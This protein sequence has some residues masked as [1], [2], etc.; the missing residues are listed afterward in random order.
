MNAI[1]IAVLWRPRRN[2]ELQEEFT[3]QTLH[4]DS[5]DEALYHC[6]ALREAGFSAEL[7]Q[8]KPDRLDLVLQEI[9]KIKPALVFNA[10]SEE[11]VSFCEACR[12]P[13]VGSGIDLV[14]LDKPTRKKIWVYEGIPTPE[15]VTI[16]NRTQL[17]RVRE[18]LARRGLDFPLF[19]KP[20]KGRG[21]SGITE[22]SIVYDESGLSEAAIRILQN[23]RQLVLVEK[24][25]RGR[26]ISIGLIGN[27]DEITV[28]P[29]L[30]V[31]YSDALTNT[32]AH[33]MSD[34]E[35]LICPVPLPSEQAE[36]LRKLA[37]RAYKALGARDYGRI[38]IMLEG[39]KPYFLE[40]NTF[41]GLA[42]PGGE[43]PGQD[44]A[45]HVSY[46]GKMAASLGKPRSWLVGSIVEAA[47]KR[48]SGIPKVGY[49]A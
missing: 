26:E 42:S 21:S 17:N 12:I 2:T 8:W 31:G 35:V 48:Y 13:Y 40:L 20:A 24:Y 1:K 38:D 10:S 33:K 37:I 16:S 23:L 49:V 15:F 11:E 7:V 46:M 29:L 19:V 27:G 44:S 22:D 30:E 34:K 28:L 47:L 43:G 3:G 5:R 45:I 25:I 18:L 14:P 39:D 32:Y 41:P 36:N 4:D 6:H 9:N